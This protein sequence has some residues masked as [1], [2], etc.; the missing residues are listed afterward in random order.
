M[1]FFLE[2]LMHMKASGITPSPSCS[3]HQGASK[4]IQDDFERPCQHLTSGQGYVVIQV[5]H[6]LHV[7]RCVV[8]KKT[9]LEH[10][11]VSIAP[12]NR[13]L[14]AK[15]ADLGGSDAYRR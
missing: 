5:E 2:F 8:M 4:H 7:S 9:H 11:H 6:M 13:E 15:K 3:S 1:F 12:F 10:A 14:F